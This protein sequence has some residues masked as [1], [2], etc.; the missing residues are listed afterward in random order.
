MEK[1]Q[2]CK[3][4]YKYQ[5]QQ[6]IYFVI[7][8]Q[9]L[10]Y[11][12]WTHFGRAK[13]KGHT[14][15]HTYTI[16]Q[17]SYQ[18]STFCTLWNPRNSQDKILKLMVTM[19]RSKVKPRSHHDNAQPHPLFN[20]PDQVSTSYTLRFLRYSPD[21]ILSV[22]LTLARSKVKSRSHNDVVHLHPLI[23]VPT[24]YQL[25]TPYGFWDIA[26]T[27]LCRSR[28]LW[29]GNIAHLYPL[30]NVPTKYQLPAP[31]G[32]WDTAGQTFSRHPPTHPDTMGENSPLS[33]IRA[34]G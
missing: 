27:K 9:C 11:G 4:A 13:V 10:K 7:I 17:C 2:S 24:N 16:N 34:V 21:K 31:Y 12:R 33:P 25:P 15:M 22:K 8:E 30:T 14:M 5:L 32:F 28:S 3:S 1:A 6:S 29:Q 20:V 18:L 23:N 26:R 19:T